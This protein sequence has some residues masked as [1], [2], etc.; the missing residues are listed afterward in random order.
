MRNRVTSVFVLILLLTP[1]GRAQ[2]GTDNHTVT[3]RV[4]QITALQLSQGS[5]ALSITGAGLQAGQDTMTATHQ[6]T[7]L[8]WGT[9][10]N[11]VKTTVA[12]NLTSPRF[13]MKIVAIS[14]T[15]GTPASER[16]LS[17]TPGDFLLNMGRSS[18]TCRILYTGV[19]MAQQGTGVDNHVIT[20]TVQS[21]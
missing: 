20:F 8:S 13:T 10:L 17:T 21:Q 2:V 1:V 14:N 6:A 7:V 4:S 12:T 9:N 11:S 16:T 5:A 3:V 19:A 18:G 15:G